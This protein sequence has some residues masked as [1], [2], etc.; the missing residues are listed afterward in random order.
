MSAR[1]R[2]TSS[3]AAQRALVL[4]GMQASMAAYQRRLDLQSPE[5]MSRFYDHSPDAHSRARMSW[6][7]TFLVTVP[8]SMN[9]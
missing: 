1:P 3:F 2:P 8:R 9:F 6:V 4:Q 7:T 5:S